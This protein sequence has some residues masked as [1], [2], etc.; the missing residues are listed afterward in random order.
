MQKEI[1][2][3]ANSVKHGKHCVAGK[4]LTTGEWIRPV[5]SAQGE[6]LT[7]QQIM[8]KNKYGTFPVKPLQKVKMQLDY[9]APLGNHQPEN[10]VISGQV[11]RQDF[12]IDAS[13]L[14]HLLDYPDSLWGES[15]RIACDEA[16]K[17]YHGNGSLL[18]VQVTNLR[19]STSSGKRRA[20]FTYNGTEYD[21]PVTD[22]NFD[23]L[24]GK[25]KIHKSAVLTI[26]LGENFNDYCYKII[27][28]IFI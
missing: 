28:A 4:C 5:A 23:A 15:N 13:D 9:H 1:V 10:Y 16:K 21:F 17:G 22:P 27:A 18:L 19:L 25:I 24:H 12:K 20:S 3:L 7:S 14:K 6:E 26:S 11:W 2:V 8:V